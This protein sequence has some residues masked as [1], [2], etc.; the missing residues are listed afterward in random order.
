MDLNNY[1][2]KKA[3]KRKKIGWRSPPLTWIHNNDYIQ[4]YLKTDDEGYL[5]KDGGWSYLSSELAKNTA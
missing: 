1:Y 3:Y 4:I 2:E 5:L